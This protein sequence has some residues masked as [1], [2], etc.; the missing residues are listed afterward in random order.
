MSFFL[1]T[2]FLCGVTAKALVVDGIPDLPG[3]VDVL[4]YDTKP[5]NFI[6]MCF[7]AIKWIHKTWKLYDP[8]KMVRDPNFFRLNVKESYNNSMSSVGLSD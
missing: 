2:F 7:N 4:V 5:V 6:L 8:K 3:T 1:F